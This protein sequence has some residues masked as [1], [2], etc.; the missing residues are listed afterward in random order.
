MKAAQTRTSPDRPLLKDQQKGHPTLLPR[1]NMRTFLSTRSREMMLLLLLSSA[2]KGRAAGTQKQLPTG[3]EQHTIHILNRISVIDWYA[4]RGRP[5]PQLACIRMS[6]HLIAICH[7]K[8]PFITHPLAV[9]P[10]T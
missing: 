5:G 9:L 2:E 7:H 3:S 4:E 8:F 6:C 10:N 1:C